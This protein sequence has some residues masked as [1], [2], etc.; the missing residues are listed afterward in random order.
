MRYLITSLDPRPFLLP[1]IGAEML[2]F[3]FLGSFVSAVDRDITALLSA[4]M[5]GLVMSAVSAA[6]V[7]LFSLLYDAWSAR[8]GYAS[9][10]L[11]QDQPRPD[12]DERG[13]GCHTDSASRTHRSR[14]RQ[15]P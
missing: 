7:L 9:L 6:G 4:L 2:G 5:V 11:S 12:G 14:C 10:T 13:S 8:F 3:L 1:L 15:M